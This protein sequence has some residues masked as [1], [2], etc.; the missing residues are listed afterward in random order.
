M[1][2]VKYRQNTAEKLKEKYTQMN[3]ELHTAQNLENVCVVICRRTEIN[4]IVLRKLSYYI[5]STYQ[6]YYEMTLILLPAVAI[7]NIRN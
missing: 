3:I 1:I 7:L 2:L 5:D 6:L 4:M